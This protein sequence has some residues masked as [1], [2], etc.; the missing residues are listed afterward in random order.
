[1]KCIFC[2]NYSDNCVSIE[3]II[4]ESL[5]NK[6]HVLP[7]GV[8][9][10]SC[11][12]YF[13][14][15]IEKPLLELPY[16]RSARFRNEI[17][18]KKGR[19]T[20]DKGIMGGIVSIGKD[21]QGLH[22]MSENPIVAKG[23]MEGSIKHM[24]LAYNSEPESND[25]NV[26]KFLCKAA[27]ESLIYRVGPVQEWLDEITEHSQ[28]DTIRNYVRYGSKPKFWEYHQRRIYQEGDEFFNENVSSETYEILHEFNFFYSDEGELFYV[29]VIMGIEFA[30]SLSSEKISGYRKWLIQNSGEA[31][32][33][34]HN[35]I[36]VKSNPKDANSW[37]GKK[38][39]FYTPEI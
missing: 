30:L 19:P 28:L 34:N 21:E 17:E 32:L 11:N 29:L 10:D 4:P 18:N 5:G 8:V 33:Q 39:S 13:A 20:L 35:E 27:L 1:M 26:S 24:I 9:C 3:H 25:I 6:E 15:K 36:R 14:V 16:F 22:I 12:N 31:P 38:I 2:K 37:I 23:I 7:K